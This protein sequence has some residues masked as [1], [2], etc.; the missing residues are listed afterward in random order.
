MNLSFENQ[1]ALVT[2][3]GSGMGLA[4]ARAFAEARAAV[5]LADINEDA[6]RSATEELVAAGHRAMAIHCNV[7]DEAEV[8][9]MI[10]HTVATFGH[11][12][13]AFNNAGVMIP[14]F[15]H[16]EDGFELQFGCNHLGHFALTGLLLYVALFLARRWPA[17]IVPC[18]NGRN[19]AWATTPRASWTPC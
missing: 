15:G 8:A 1:A 16:T 5:V 4:T 2:G 6:V 18:T 7:A 13:A 19:V 9:A 3:A 11:L 17:A 14:P 10:E 12:D